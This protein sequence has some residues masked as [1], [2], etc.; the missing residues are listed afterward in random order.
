MKLFLSAI[1]LDYFLHLVKIAK[2]QRFKPVSVRIKLHKFHDIM[3]MA[4]TWVCWFHVECFARQKTPKKRNAH[5]DSTQGEA[6]ALRH[7]LH[8]IQIQMD[9]R[10]QNVANLWAKCSNSARFSVVVLLTITFRNL[11]LNYH[12][13]AE[14]NLSII[15]IT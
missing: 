7:Y 6:K 11:S 8:R 14:K 15:I 3:T 5:Q 2:G 10:D 12:Q 13:F 4:N 9:S 1:I